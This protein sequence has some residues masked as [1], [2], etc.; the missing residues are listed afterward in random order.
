MNKTGGGVVVVVEDVRVGGPGEMEMELVM[1]NEWGGFLVAKG[2]LKRDWRA[3]RLG[4]G[5]TL[6]QPAQERRETDTSGH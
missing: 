6:T 5:R 1:M 2:V 3:S 4:T